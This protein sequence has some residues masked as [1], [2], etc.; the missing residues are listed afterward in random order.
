V[1]GQSAPPILLRFPLHG[2]RFG[3]LE[4]EPV[5]RPTRPTARSK[6]LRDNPLQPHLAGVLE[7]KGTLGGAPRGA[8]QGRNSPAVPH[9]LDDFDLPL[10]DQRRLPS[11]DIRPGP[12][13]T[14]IFC[15]SWK[16]ATWENPFPSAG[17]RRSSFVVCC[18]SMVS[19]R[20]DGS[21]ASSPSQKFTSDAH[22]PNCSPLWCG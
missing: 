17:G 14:E 5:R 13:V 12:F 9:A 10:G 4:F 11:P 20:F 6:S 8:D 19:R 18:R 16:V 3:V 21:C 1:N 15:I 22:S 7:H 2:W